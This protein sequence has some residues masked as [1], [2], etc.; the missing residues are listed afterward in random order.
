MSVAPGSTDASMADAA[1]TAQDA[2]PDKLDEAEHEAW[3]RCVALGGRD[4]FKLPDDELNARLTVAQRGTIR[5]NRRRDNRALLARL[6]ADAQLAV[7]EVFDQNHASYMSGPNIRTRLLCD[8]MGTRPPFTAAP[9]LLAHR[10]GMVQ[11]FGRPGSSAR[12][13]LHGVMGRLGR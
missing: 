13:S 9:T 6:E 5:R 8:V 7:S 11:I 10:G 4:Q 1:G 3:K 12:R 2:P